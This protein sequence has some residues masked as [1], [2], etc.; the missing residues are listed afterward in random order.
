MDHYIRSTAFPKAANVIATIEKQIL[1]TPESN[2]LQSQINSII[3]Q[4]KSC[5]Y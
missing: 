3:H 2:T 5:Y 4:G 1:S